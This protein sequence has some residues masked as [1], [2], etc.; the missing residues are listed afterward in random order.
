[1]EA[2]FEFLFKYRP[3]VFEKGRLVL[4]APWPVALV[5]A[6]ALAVAVPALWSYARARA[7]SRSRD[8]WILAA[9]RVGV[10][11]VLLVCLLRP[12]LVV[13]TVVPQQSFLGLLVDDSRSMQIADRAEEPRSAAVGR[14]LAPESP[15]RRALD[16]RFKV[17]LFGFSSSGERLA[18]L[19]D[20]TYA[21]ARTDLAAALTHARQEMQGVP[22]SGLVLVTDGADNGGGGLSEALLQLKAGGVPVFTVGLGSERFRRDVEVSRVDSP[23]SV[24]QGTSIL[25]SLTVA[26]RGLAGERA[27]LLVEDGD[28]VVHAREIT[29][30]DHGEPAVVRAQVVADQPGARV[31]RFRVAPLA[32]EALDQNNEQQVLVNVLD[33]REKIL[34]HEGEARFE[35]KFI[36]RAVAD[37]PN[38][39]VV[40]LQRT[41]KKKFLRLDVDDADELA[42]GFPETREAL[43]RY[44]G[45]VL[46]SVE[47]SAFTADQLRM[48]ADFVSLRGGGL[49]MLGGSGSFGEGGYAGTPLA[50]ALPVALDP[51]PAAG[52]EPQ[53][54]ELRIEPTPFGLTHAVTQLAATEPESEK[55]WRTLPPLT[56]RNVVHRTRPGAAT[57]L[58]GR[59]AGGEPQ[60]V[61][62]Y[63][64]Y[65][66]G[67]SLALTVQDTWLWQMHA[68]IPLE[69]R[70]HENLWRQL[71]RWLVADVPGPVA[72]TLPEDQVA[73]GTSVTLRAEVADE[74]YL[75]VNDASVVATVTDPAGE[76]RDLAMEWT[77]EK[78]GEYRASFVPAEPGIY[79][80]DVLARRGGATLGSDRIHLR[81]ADLPV[82]FR[83]AEM[84]AALLQRIAD[85][86]GGHFYTADTVASLAEDITYTGGGSTVTESKDLWDMPALY[87]LVVILVS[88]EWAYRRA[89]GLA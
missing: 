58:L 21:G 83:G 26:Q 6:V 13:A 56:A 39:Q 32:G 50:E 46:G 28:L 80:V 79:Q 67:K 89:R 23:R 22:L 30:P 62:A 76:K 45:L 12:T 18:R 72:I 47:A 68:E 44:R 36:R 43:Y 55:R 71:L 84:R 78:D 19:S 51:P 74:R 63:Q 33:R 9:L 7:K 48:I 15:L 3:L 8:R 31:L 10:L 59:P 41:A 49:L 86:T 69:D 1:M 37:D 29:L 40:T 75:R 85:E 2:A 87:L 65:G 42:G 5:A 24:L 20:L 38:L 4:A 14:L 27:R 61:L 81:V 82:E 54:A 66:R 73:P 34:Y 52:A 88:S 60:V 16:A 35:P 57:L 77:V 70:T 17:R 11:L 53:V 25:A 64:R